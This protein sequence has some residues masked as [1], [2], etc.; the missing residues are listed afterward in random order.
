MSILNTS[1][2][3]A[4]WAPACTG[5]WT[6]I[7]LYGEGS[8]SVRPAC[9]DAFRA[10]NACLVAHG[11]RTRRGD[12][13]AFNCRRI[14]GGTGYSLHAYGIAADIN[15]TTNPYGPRLV[16]DMPAAMRTAIKALRTRSGRQVFGWGGDYRSNKDAMHWEVVCSP[17]DMATGVDPATVP[18]TVVEPTDPNAGRTWRPFKSPATDGSIYAAGGHRFEVSEL[19][20]RL[21]VPVDGIYGAASVAAWVAWQA[22]QHEAY[23]L[24]PRWLPSARNSAVTVDKVAALRKATGG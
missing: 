6:R 4:A 23:P 10:L 5:P 17:A 24:D 16:T 14:T 8:I 1:Q 9:A 12:T 13:G 2:L 22:A 15:W 3:R 20:I 19:Q 7:A 11:Y 18:G 21:R